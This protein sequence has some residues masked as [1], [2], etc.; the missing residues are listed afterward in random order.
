[1]SDDYLHALAAY[2]AALDLPYPPPQPAAAPPAVLER[3][4]VLVTQGDKER[5]IP[6][7]TECHGAALTGVQPAVPGLLGLSR[8]YLNSQLGAWRTGQR[9]AHA[10]D[11]M[12]RI[13]RQLSPEDLSAVAAWLAAQPL[14][15]ETRAVASLPQPPSIS[16]GSAMLPAGRQQP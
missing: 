13:A 15:R 10:P 2:Y 6:A 5:N 8:D 9:R 16:C 14:P 4:R 7:C 11:C 3:G 12:S 1:M